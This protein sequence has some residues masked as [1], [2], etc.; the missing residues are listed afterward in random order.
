M[1][2]HVTLRTSDLEGTRDFIETVLGFKPGYRPAFGFPGYWLYDGAEPIVHLIPGR[3]GAVDRSGETID[4]VA[5]RIDDYDGMR[6]RLDNLAIVYSRMELRELNER[7]LFI[8]TPAGVLLEL[9]CR[10]AV[11]TPNERASDHAH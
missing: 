8:R 10:A 1:L 3:G 2:D 4:H 11:T 6:R 7:R 5:F 9:V